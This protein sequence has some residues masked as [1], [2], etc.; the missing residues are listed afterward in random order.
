MQISELQFAGC[1]LRHLDQWQSQ[2]DQSEVHRWKY[3]Q[4]QPIFDEFGRI[5]HGVQWKRSAGTQSG[6]KPIVL[7][8]DL[9]KRLAFSV[10]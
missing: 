10:G 9:P 3:S 6:H 1:I 7:E 2:N 8:E 4:F 5:D